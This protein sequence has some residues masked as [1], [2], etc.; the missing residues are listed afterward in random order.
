M[1]P[2]LSSRPRWGRELAIL[3]L[4]LV[5]AAAGSAAWQW[6]AR[7]RTV[8]SLTPLG[9]QCAEVPGDTRRVT[10]R[11]EDGTTIGAARVGPP[12]AEPAV[13]L[14]HGASQT[15]CDWLPWA[16]RL[17]Q[18]TGAQVLLFDRRGHGSTPARESLSAE[19][20]DLA[21]AVALVTDDVTDDQGDRPVVL[22]ASSMGNAVLWSG[23]EQLPVRPCAA[24]AVSPVLSA[25]EQD[26]RV[27][28]VPEQVAADAW[29]EEVWVA[30][31]N[32][33]AGVA[34]AAERL[35][36]AAEAAGRP[37][38]RSPVDTD[39]HSR[40]LVEGH[41]EVADLVTAAVRGCA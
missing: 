22:V 7:N 16:A 9:E 26:D 20:S 34:E 6:W 23:L 19:P 21:R 40:R 10:F 3:A 39:D 5:V 12:S 28:A 37:T 17:H 1:A 29:P 30:W 36:G 13:V 2:E 38:Q 32:R 27:A 41:R 25:G 31:E 24:V 35:L 33:S 14:R 15:L 18:E 11:G 4:V 8:A